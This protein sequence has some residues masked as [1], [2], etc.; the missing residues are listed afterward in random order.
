M[1]AWCYTIPVWLPDLVRKHRGDDFLQGWSLC[2]HL[3]WTPFHVLSWSRNNTRELCCILRSRCLNSQPNCSLYCTLYCCRCSCYSFHFSFFSH[4]HTHH[5]PPYSW[6][7]LCHSYNNGNCRC[8]RPIDRTFSMR[9]P[10]GSILE[11]YW[12]H[13]CCRQ[14][15]HSLQALQKLDIRL[16]C[17]S[18]QLTEYM[19]LLHYVVIMF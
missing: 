10:C 8:R 15:S 2:L 1:I 6:K 11:L 16:F 7:G 17:L 13:L 5:L 18:F 9:S 14:T 4:S 12:Q 3:G 19:L